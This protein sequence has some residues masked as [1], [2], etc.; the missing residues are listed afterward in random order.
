MSA[1]R[2]KSKSR[3]GRELTLYSVGSHCLVGVLVGTL[4]LSC[5]GA[6]TSIASNQQAKEAPTL[7]GVTHTAST[8]AAEVL[9]RVSKRVEGIDSPELPMRAPGLAGRF[10]VESPALGALIGGGFLG[11]SNLYLFFDGRYIYSEWADVE[12]ETLYE[13]GVWRLVDGVLHLEAELVARKSV[14]LRDRSFVLCTH[15][16]GSATKLR[17]IG[18]QEQVRFIEGS[19]SND[20]QLTLLLNSLEQVEKYETERRSRRAQK[21]LL[22]HLRQHP[23]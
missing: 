9:S 6:L 7:R 1:P 8:A 2:A 18:T 10:S 14:H 15:R 13:K 17:L 16:F 3:Q 23:E 12:P 4:G 21:R 5:S 20:P 19:E 11:G 22:H